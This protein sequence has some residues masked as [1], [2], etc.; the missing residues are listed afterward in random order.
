MISVRP[1]YVSSL[2]C[3]A[4]CI[5]DLAALY[6]AKLLSVIDGVVPT[7]NVVCRSWSSNGWFDSGCRYA[8]RILRLERA[9]SAAAKCNDCAFADADKMA[10]L[11][12]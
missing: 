6:D 4:C 8:K 3:P 2:C 10:W 11:Q 9:A 7:R 1:F 12:Q 5:H